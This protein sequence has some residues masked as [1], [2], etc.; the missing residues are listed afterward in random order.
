[1]KDYQHLI[2]N[3]LGRIESVGDLQSIFVMDIVKEEPGYPLAVGDD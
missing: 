3:V 2:L 1:M